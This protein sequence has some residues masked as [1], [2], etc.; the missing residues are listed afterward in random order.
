MR[1]GWRAATRSAAVGGVLLAMIEGLQ[2]F[3]TKMLA[4]PAA[5][6]YSPPP[7]APPPQA[8]GRMVAPGPRAVPAGGGGEL[9]QDAAPQTAAE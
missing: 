1:G 8:G 2:I 5:P 7:T 3:M 9:M 6:P 4:E